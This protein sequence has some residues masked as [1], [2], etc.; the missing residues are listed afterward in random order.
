[1]KKLSAGLALSLFLLS[2]Q[3]T[4]S[5]SE[6]QTLISSRGEVR[7]PLPS[8]IEEHGFVLSSWGIEQYGPDEWLFPYSAPYVRDVIIPRLIDR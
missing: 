4:A 8:Y 1:M 7:Y 5:F 6:S 2:S 3:V